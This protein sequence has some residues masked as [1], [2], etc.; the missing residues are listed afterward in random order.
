MFEQT[1]SCATCGVIEQR[2]KYERGVGYPLEWQFFDRRRRDTEPDKYTDASSSSSTSTSTSHEEDAGERLC[3]AVC[4]AAVT[5]TAE[6]LERDR[7]HEHYFTNPHGT[8]YRIGCFAHAVGL[9]ALGPETDENT[10]FAGYRWRIMLCAQCNTLLGWRFRSP[11]D[12]FFGLIVAHLLPCR[13]I[14][15]A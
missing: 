5:T 8:G 10:W 2:G 6:A 13:N 1:N 3:C 12:T 11:S 14:G 9:A 15:P 7:Q 4:A